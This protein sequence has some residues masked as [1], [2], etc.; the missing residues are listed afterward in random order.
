MQDQKNNLSISNSKKKQFSFL[1]WVLVFFIPVI[2]AIGIVE[3]LVLQIPL[4]YVVTSDQLKIDKDSIEIMVLGSSQVYRDINPKYIER[5]SIN[6]SSSSQHHNTDFEILSQTTDRLPN[7]KYVV[8]ELSYGHLVLP[9]NTKK[10]WKNNV[11]L[12][13]YDVNNFGR[14]TY[15]KDKLIYLSNPNLYSKYLMDHYVRKSK[16]PNLNEYGFD[17]DNF[18]GIFKRL[19]YVED[20]IHARDFEINIAANMDL[21]EENVAYFLR[22]LDFANK[23]NLM[24]IVS[25]MPMYKDYLKAREPEIARRRDSVLAI[26]DQQ[27]KNVRI[28]HQENDTITYGVKDF[29]N[30]NHLNPRGAEKFTKALNRFILTEHSN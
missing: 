20:D 29:V 16:G 13:Y 23:E 8:L 4:S 1:K 21:F 24:V 14:K 30:F 25:T 11:F 9:H 12:K 28:F 6:L 19:D 18:D 22:I 7:L 26:I 5:P 17:E 27:Y 3:Y 10:F 15:F 2:V